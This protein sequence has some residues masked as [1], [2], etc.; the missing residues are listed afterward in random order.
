VQTT[1]RSAPVA[2][3]T[4]PDRTSTAPEQKTTPRAKPSSSPQRTAPTK[5]RPQP[6]APVTH[7]ATPAAVPAAATGD[8]RVEPLLLAALAFLALALACASFAHLLV[9]SGTW[10]RA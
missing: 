4:K 5:T 6:S 2:S 8:E 7:R 1:T 3:T 9:R 10:K